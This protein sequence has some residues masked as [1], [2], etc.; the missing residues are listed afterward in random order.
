MLK[1]VIFQ[2]RFWTGFPERGANGPE[3]D[4]EYAAGHLR[5]VVEAGTEPFEVRRA[6]IGARG[7]GVERDR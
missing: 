4:V 6:P 5:S 1:T 3:K 2:S 7:A